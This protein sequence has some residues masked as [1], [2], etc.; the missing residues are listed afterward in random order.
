MSIDDGITRVGQ[1]SSFRD[2]CPSGTGI[3]YASF[4]GS[5]TLFLICDAAFYKSREVDTLALGLGLGFGLPIGILLVR[6]LRKFLVRRQQQVQEQGLQE[7]QLQE[8][9]PSS[10]PPVFPAEEVAK[11]LSLL[12]L[13][14]FRRGNMTDALKEELMITR[15]RLGCDLTDFVKY[16]DQL[17]HTELA[18]YI[19]RMNVAAIPPEIHRKAHYKKEAFI[20]QVD[21]DSES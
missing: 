19:E 16:A 1:S 4:N 13:N 6:L 11:H 9:G 20:V 18:E 8:Q 10:Y 12:A 3:G 7:Q 21:P 15:V 17:H 5:D 14:D 2:P